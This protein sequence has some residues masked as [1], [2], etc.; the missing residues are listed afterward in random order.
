MAAGSISFL[1][2]SFFDH[3][4]VTTTGATA[5][6]WASEIVL[7]RFCP[8]CWYAARLSGKRQKGKS[9]RGQDGEDSLSGSGVGDID[10]EIG[11]ETRA[12]RHIVDV[13][14]SKHRWTLVKYSWGGGWQCV[15]VPFLITSLKSANSVVALRTALSWLVFWIIDSRQQ[16]RISEIQ[17]YHIIISKESFSQIE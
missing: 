5:N 7:P 12:K 14:S 10:I 13:V 9:K 3:S 2:F 1:P 17:K 15:S 4:L 6:S 11:A 8:E 16:C